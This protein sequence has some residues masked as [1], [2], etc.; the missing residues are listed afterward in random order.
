MCSKKEWTT[1]NHDG[2]STPTLAKASRAQAGESRLGNNLLK[3]S[4]TK[5]GNLD[6]KESWEK[7]QKPGLKSKHFIHCLVQGR[8]KNS[9]CLQ[10]L[11][12]ATSSST[13]TERETRYSKQSCSWLL[14]FL[15]FVLFWKE[16]NTKQVW[17]PDP[18]L[19]RNVVHCN[20]V[21][22]WRFFGDHSVQ[23]C[24]LG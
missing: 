16:V 15:Y 1:S 20:Q 8:T 4:S 5:A 9:T 3:K 13:A 21:A 24:P 12:R 7:R 19:V 17:E 10:Q 23:K 14:L 6:K 22:G 2:R 18:H 11:T